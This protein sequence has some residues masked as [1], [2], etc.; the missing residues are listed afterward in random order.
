MLV[1]T[2]L[3]VEM[4]KIKRGRVEMIKIKIGEEEHFVGKYQKRK[5]K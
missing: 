5:I 4:I 2:H 3:K 1:C